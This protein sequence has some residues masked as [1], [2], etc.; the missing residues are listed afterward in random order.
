[1]ILFIILISGIIASTITYFLNNK[2]G[3]GAV[4]ASSLVSVIAGLIVVIFSQQFSEELNGTFPMVIMGAS[5]VGMASRKVAK[6][7][8]VIILSGFTFS[9]LFYCTGTFFEGFG[10]SLG[11]TA[12]IA[13]CSTL[14]I[15]NLIL[16]YRS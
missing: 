13:F 10:G 2:F 3:L 16:Q 8:L 15:R 1:M 7:Y 9:L 6:N 4:M 5:F 12:A 11:T 14:G